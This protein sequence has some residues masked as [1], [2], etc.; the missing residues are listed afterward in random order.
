[1]FR[2]IWTTAILLA[3]SVGIA[4]ATAGAATAGERLN[5]CEPLIVR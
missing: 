1:M 2:K 3:T 5:H 4:A